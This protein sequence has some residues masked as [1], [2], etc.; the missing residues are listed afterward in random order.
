VRITLTRAGAGKPART[1]SRAGGSGNN[2]IAISLRGL[3][4]GRYRV[5]VS[6]S[7]VSSNKTAAQSRTLSVRR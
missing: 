3:R 7:D 1:L 5:A 4:P 6:A 2:R